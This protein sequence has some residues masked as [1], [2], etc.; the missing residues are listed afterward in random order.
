MVE[1]LMVNNLQVLKAVIPFGKICIYMIQTVLS[2]HCDGGHSNLGA[3][4]FY[5]SGFPYP[6][7]S[8]EAIEDVAEDMRLLPTMFSKGVAKVAILR[9]VGSR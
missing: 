5:G 8:V 1:A 7:T 3:T 4:N 2:G 9:K 6:D